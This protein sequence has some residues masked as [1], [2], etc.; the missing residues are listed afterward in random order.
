LSP[1]AVPFGP[2][3]VDVVVPGTV[4]GVSAVSTP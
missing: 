1:G 2:I 4:V 3:S